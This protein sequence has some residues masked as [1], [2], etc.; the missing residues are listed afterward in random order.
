[1]IL[2]MKFNSL[3]RAMYLFILIVLPLLSFG[4]DQ[5]A[6]LF[7]K[8][9]ASYAKGHYKEALEAY[10]KILKENS[11]S[12]ELWFNMGNASY[13]MDDIPSALLYYERAH[14]LSPDDEDIKVNIRLANLK[15]T[16]KIE[17]APR[18]F[19]NRWWLSFILSFSSFVLSVWSIILVLLGSAALIL[20][21]FAESPVIK[22]ASFYTAVLLFFLGL[23]TVFVAGR[24]VSYFENHKQGIV[25]V[26][27]L[28]VKSTP[29]EQ[30]KSLF[31]LHEGTKV[32]IVENSGEWIKIRL[33][34][35]TEG[36]VRQ[37][38]LKEI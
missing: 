8:G 12:A 20:Y 7:A 22:R 13:R 28:A 24:Q 27:P 33:A 25:F 17:E 15:T 37:A 4:N 3:K 9:N 30:P 10:Q 16:D 6:A 32:N 26:S 38:D 29:A 11:P 5:A 35:G 36:W 31:I 18:F 21:F 23:T 1:M 34:N 19:L 2:R 14:K